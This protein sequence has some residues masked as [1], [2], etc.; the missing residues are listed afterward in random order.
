MAR[1]VFEETGLHLTRFVRQVGPGYE[2]PIKSLRSAGMCLKLTFEIEVV[3]IRQEGGE[4]SLC[5][6]G[7]SGAGGAVMD[8]DEEGEKENDR[9]I[10][11]PLN[12]ELNPHE[13]QAYRWVSLEDIIG[14]SDPPSDP[15]ED[16]KTVNESKTN[17]EQSSNPFSLA[18]EQLKEV[19]IQAFEEHDKGKAAI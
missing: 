17:A 4:G 9:G 13:H 6:S 2:F 15:K 3:E 12:I 8:G 18:T 1:E 16:I 11:P 5:H 14:S 10:K 19:L 7:D